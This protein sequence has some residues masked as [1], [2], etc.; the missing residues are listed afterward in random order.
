MKV[1]WK[2]VFP[3]LIVKKYLH[4]YVIMGI[5]VNETKTTTTNKTQ[6]IS[7]KERLLLAL[8]C[9]SVIVFVCLNTIFIL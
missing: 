1:K 6:F 3:L 2:S 8:K 5:K 7:K 4:N 9:V